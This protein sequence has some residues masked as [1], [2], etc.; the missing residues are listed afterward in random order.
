FGRMVPG[1]RELISIPAGFT[2]MKLEKYIIY[3]FSGSIIWSTFL[4]SVGYYFGEN[5]KH[6]G[7][8]DLSSFFGILVFLAIAT[9]LIFKKLI[10]KYSKKNLKK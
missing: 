7:I 1:I 9:Y 5:W 4:I 6:F 2:K 8:G 10:L 3:T